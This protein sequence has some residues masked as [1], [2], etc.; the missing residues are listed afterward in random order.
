MHVKTYFSVFPLFS[1]E[2]K[3][4]FFKVVKCQLPK[5]L[6]LLPAHYKEDNVEVI[7]ECAHFSG[8]IPPPPPLSL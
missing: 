1:Y 8:Q 2:N 5:Y 6:K 7:K 3:S 4:S